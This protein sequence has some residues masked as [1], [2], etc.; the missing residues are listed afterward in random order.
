MAHIYNGVLLSH[1]K[2]HKQQ[3]LERVW[4]KGNAL[5]LLVGMYIDAATMEGGM[6][7]PKKLGHHMAQQFH[8]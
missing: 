1:I 4:R 5:A 6:E 7:I 2:V 3:V 8:S